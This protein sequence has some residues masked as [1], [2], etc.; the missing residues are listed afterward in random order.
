MAYHCTLTRAI[1]KRYPSSQAYGSQGFRKVTKLKSQVV[2][3]ILRMGYDVTWTD[4]DIAWLKNPI[5]LMAAMQSDF[6]VQS[7]AP[8]TEAD[9][10]G[11][12][13]I[14]SGFYR[15]RSS[16]QTVA[17]MEQI[18]L[19]AAAST[20]TEQPSF[21]MVLCGGKEGKFK[22]GDS[23]CLYPGPDGKS[24]NDRTPP[25]LVDYLSRDLYPAGAYKSLWDD[26]GI[27]HNTE[28]VILHNNWIS[29][30]K[31][32]I[33]RLIDRRLWYYNREKLIC[34]YDPDPTFVLD[35]A[36]EAD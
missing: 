30:M 23:Q 1:S 11:P 9:A 19:H 27:R 13:R 12:L 7:N 10:N 29:G 3:A 8:S 20:L 28:L 26:E 5:P 17:A 4:T 32:K 31:N 34:S 35:W 22:K 36:I 14:N 24:Q 16:R 18:V 25:L 2:L 33:Q 21:Y 15:V 6:V